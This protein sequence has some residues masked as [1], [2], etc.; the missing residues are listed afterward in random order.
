VRNLQALGVRDLL[1]YRTSDRPLPLDAPPPAERD[2]EQALARRP[3]ATLVCNPTAL[4]QPTAL[5]AA[6]AGSHLFVEKPISHSLDGVAALRAE[7]RRRGLVA[8]VGFQFR[9]HPAI[10]KVKTWLEEGALGE[11]VSARAV[12]GEYLP[13]WHPGEDYRTSYSARRDLGGGALLTLCHPFDYLRFLLG[14]VEGVQAMAT[15]RS[16][17]VLDVEDVAHVL[18]RFASGALGAVSLDY[19]TRP[20]THG[21][22]IVGQDALVRWSDTD[23]VARLLT[24]DGRVTRAAPPVGFSRNTM[25]VEEMRHFLRCLSGQEQPRCTLEDGERAL[26]IALGARRAAESGECVGV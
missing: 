25:F 17:L 16:G 20:S 10:Q 23:G 5:A 4:H 18:L 12:W 2:W 19:A 15:R 11:V 13:D 22:E 7:V 8:L 1:L 9:F 6:R 26:R 14:E 3:F 21:F 24:K